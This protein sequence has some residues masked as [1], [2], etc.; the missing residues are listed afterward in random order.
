MPNTIPVMAVGPSTM[1]FGYL[2]P[3]GLVVGEGGGTFMLSGPSPF[4]DLRIRMPGPLTAHY[5][6][7]CGSG[8]FL[9]S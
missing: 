7:A 6:G 4:K 8:W 3:P 1:I 2:H 9:I 5:L